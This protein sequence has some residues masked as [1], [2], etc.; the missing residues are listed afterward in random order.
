MAAKALTKK[1]IADLEKYIIQTTSLKIACGCAGVPSSTF[2]A[3][4]K[5]AKEIEEE[6]KDESDLTKDEALLLEFLERIDLAKAK[7]CKPAIDA[8][9]Q[10]IKDGDANQAAR[11]LSRRLPEEFGD[12]NRKEVTIKQE[13][14]EESSTGIA[15][16]PSMG[17]DSDLDQLLQQQQSD[18]L[19]LA[20]TKTS[21]LS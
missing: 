11:L 5:A 19:Q 9:M 8:V 10:A 3:W 14:T 13:I 2:Y 20:K 18:A 17:S 12:W 21:E 4:Q 6:A 15:L 16:I 1:I 7:S